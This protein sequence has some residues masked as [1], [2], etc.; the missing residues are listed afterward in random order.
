MFHT[1][2]ASF[3]RTDFLLSLKTFVTDPVVC[4]K[5]NHGVCDFGAL[6]LHL[7]NDPGFV[8]RVVGFDL[9]FVFR[10]LGFD[11]GFHRLGC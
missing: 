3:F 4:P 11:S 7:G 9:G 5:A 6:W 1:H 2:L 10:V 8:F